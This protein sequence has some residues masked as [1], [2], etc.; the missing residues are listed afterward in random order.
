MNQLNS[1]WRDTTG[2]RVTPEMYIDSFGETLYMVGIS[3]F[4]GALLG[5]PLALAFVITRPGGLKPNKVVYSV[6]NV[7]VNIIRSLPFIILLVAISPFTRV[8]AGTAIGTTAALV[9]LTLYI[10]PF[11]AR[12]IEQS[13]LEVNPGITEAADSM[14]ASLF[15]TIRYFL[16]PE[17][18]SSIILAVTTATIG[19]ISAT[20]MA[21]TIGGGGVGDLAISYGYQQFDSIAMLTTV[22]LLIIIVQAI[23]SVGNTLARRARA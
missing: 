15:Q 18:K 4:L 5:I 21:G 8:I 23:Q 16:L 2:S 7:V 10:A 12:L 14:G 6:L 20:A 17:A 11:I 13:L 3:L 9:P 22:V 1:W 19:L